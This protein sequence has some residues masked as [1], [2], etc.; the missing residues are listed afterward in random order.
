MS[1]RKKPEHTVYVSDCFGWARKKTNTCK[2]CADWKTCAQYHREIVYELNALYGVDNWIAQK[3]SCYRGRRAY[4]NPAQ[5]F[6][7]PVPNCPVVNGCIVVLPPLF[8]LYNGRILKRKLGIKGN[9]SLEYDWSLYR[10][11]YGYLRIRKVQ[12]EGSAD[13]VHLLLFTT[14]DN[15]EKIQ[16]EKHGKE[17]EKKNLSNGSEHDGEHQTEPDSSGCK[18]K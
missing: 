5:L 14:R 12:Q 15:Y 10:S 16:E 1:K 4:K 11:K 2:K 8:F 7:I 3:D 13:S 18:T 6:Q 9:L 17:K